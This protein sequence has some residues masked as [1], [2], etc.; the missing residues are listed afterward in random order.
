MKICE[1][2]NTVK[3]TITYAVYYNSRHMNKENDII[4]SVGATFV[5]VHPK[6]KF[7][8]AT[9]EIKKSLIASDIFEPTD[10]DVEIVIL[11]ITKLD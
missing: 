9:R 8:S 1:K 6:I 11:S 10:T 7:F 3:D 4:Y 5:T 2:N